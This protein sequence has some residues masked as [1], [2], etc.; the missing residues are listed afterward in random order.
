MQRLEDELE[1][2]SRD[3]E[4]LIE[5]GTLSLSPTARQSRVR[6]ISEAESRA[7]AARSLLGYGDGPLTNLQS[8]VEKLGLLAFSYDLGPHVIDGCYVRLGEVGVA[9]VNG[10]VDAGRRRFN[11]AHELG[12]SQTSTGQTSALVR[13]GTTARH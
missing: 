13:H 12:H 5:I 11:L 6:T 10:S 8:T 9:L 3:V 2:T 7:S 1:K 4:L